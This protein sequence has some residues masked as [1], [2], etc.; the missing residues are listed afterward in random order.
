MANHL[1]TGV[2]GA[3]KTLYGVSRVL[4]PLI[5]SMVELEDGAKVKRRLC[6]GGVRDLLIEHEPMDVPQF[7]PEGGKLSLGGRVFDC[8]TQ[9]RKPGEPPHE[10]EMR[11]DNW[12][13]WC[14]PG[15]VIFIDECQ[16]LFRPM[17]SG[18]KLP[19][20]ITRLETHRHY[21]VDFIF[22]TQHPQL[23][24]ANVRNLVGQHN[25][26]RRVF[27]SHTTIVY[28][29]DHCT[30]PDRIK[31]AS[32]KVWRHDK[33]AYSLYKSAEVH[34][35]Q[36]HRLPVAVYV[37][38]LGLVAI[39]VTL[40]AAKE[41][42]MRDRFGGVADV[43][44]SA[45]TAAA[46]SPAQVA[47][48]GGAGDNKSPV[49]PV[50]VAASAVVA[51]PTYAGCILMAERCEC[52]D[53]AGRSVEMLLA[54]CQMGAQRGGTVVPYSVGR[55][56]NDRPMAALAMRSAGIAED[57]APIAPMPSGFNAGDYRQRAPLPHVR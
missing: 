23:L 20:F 53:L 25:H 57:P 7:D 8:D 44:A 42:L 50:A 13:R 43:A 55:A 54:S 49:A 19:M 4:A 3:G 18:R 21:G 10:C 12:W 41:R 27:G 16:R 5:G 11:A 48:P 36:K 26:V 52:I 22:I 24:H 45:P 1:V 40:Y 28:E 14:M 37:L 33:R 39:P 2:P 30:H 31:T 9:D 51:P 17:A 47:R 56:G 34:T 29:W 6:I 32:S 15:E 38:V 46:S 35:K